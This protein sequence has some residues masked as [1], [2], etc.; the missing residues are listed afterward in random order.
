MKHF[1]ESEAFSSRTFV[2]VSLLRYLIHLESETFSESRSFF[3]E[4]NLLQSFSTIAG[5]QLH[6][7]HHQLHLQLHHGVPRGSCSSNTY[8]LFD[9]IALA[10]WMKVEK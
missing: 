9:P 3:L 8:L 1:S 6:H 10:K 5:D 2:N 4:K 7:L